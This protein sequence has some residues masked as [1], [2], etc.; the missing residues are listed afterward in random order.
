MMELLLTLMRHYLWLH[1]FLT[2]SKS[3]DMVSDELIGLP[4]LPMLSV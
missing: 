3:H 1:T 2:L 4:W